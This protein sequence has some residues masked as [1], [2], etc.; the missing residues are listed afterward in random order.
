MMS[1]VRMARAQSIAKKLTR[2]AFWG[3]LSALAFGSACSS[4]DTAKAAEDN[5]ELQPRKSFRTTGEH[6]RNHRQRRRRRRRAMTRRR[7]A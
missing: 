3:L 5:R 2:V 1:T 6:P 7:N 4:V